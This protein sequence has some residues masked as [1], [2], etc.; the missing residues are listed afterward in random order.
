[1][2]VKS[3]GLDWKNEGDNG[4]VSDVIP[5]IKHGLAELEQHPEMYKQY[6]A[7]NGWGT[8]DGCKRFFR[9][10]LADWYVAQKKPYAHLM[11][12]FIN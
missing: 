8:I 10:I 11:K 2:I 12:F 3:T 5:Y 7:P 9:D 4:F 6:E 1:M